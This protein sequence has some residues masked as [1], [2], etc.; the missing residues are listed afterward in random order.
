MEINGNRNAD[1]VRFDHELHKDN[2]GGNDS[3]KS[4]H[5]LDLPGDKS[6][7]CYKCHSDMLVAVS[8]FDHSSHEKEYGGNNSCIECHDLS[9]PKNME[10]SKEC[11]ECHEKDMGMEKPKNEKFNIYAD[12]YYD[13]MH[14]LCIE[15]HKKK[16]AELNKPE[17]EEC[18][19]CHGKAWEEKYK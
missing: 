4:C 9:L 12:S 3:C 17:M 14:G 7:S 13:A 18:S 11:F 1:F 8:I 2:L 15:C 5:H 6:S 10:N 16:G 19:F